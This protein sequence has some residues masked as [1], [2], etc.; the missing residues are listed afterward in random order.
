MDAM[1]ICGRTGLDGAASFLGM[2]SVMMAAMML[3]SLLPT[4][5]RYR[6]TLGCQML[7][8]QTLDNLPAG[9]PDLLTALVGAGYLAVWIAS[10]LIVLPLDAAVTAIESDGP[11]V[12]GAIVVMAGMFQF[13][14]W[15]TRTLTGC[16]EMPTRDRLVP[17][18]AVTAWRHGVRLGVHCVCSCAGLTA[19]LLVVGLMDLR[20]MLLVTAAV[21]LERLAPNGP[22]TA[23]ALG[24]VIVAIGLLLGARGIALA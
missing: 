9:R 24:I 20:A 14:A 22:R 1:P 11:L 6:Q 10:G 8:G 4:L 19:V 21:T 18:N 3:P 23:Q 5:W 13:T 12:P 2:W 15:K 7:D 16:R 17:A